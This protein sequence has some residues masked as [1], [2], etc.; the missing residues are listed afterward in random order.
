MPR[1]NAPELLAFLAREFPQS[2]PERYRIDAVEDGRLVVRYSTTDA[3]LRPGDT[4]A[5]PTLMSLADVGMYLAVLSAIGP[6]ALAVTTNLAINFL[7]KPSPGELT[8][9]TLLLK[10]GKQLAVGEVYIRSAAGD[11]LAHATVTYSIPRRG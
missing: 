3:D 5:G 11:V 1:M 9:E 10:L 6:V 7:R 8:A 2:R 4:I